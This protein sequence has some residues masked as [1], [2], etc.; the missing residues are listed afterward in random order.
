MPQAGSKQVHSKREKIS[1]ATTTTGMVNKAPKIPD[2]KNMGRKARIVVIV[3]VTGKT[4]PSRHQLRHLPFFT[5]FSMPVIFSATTMASSTG[6]PK[7]RCH[8]Y[9]SDNMILTPSW[10]KMT[11]PRREGIP[12]AVRG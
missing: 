12:K 6:G 3:V 2:K 10:K 9:Q 1:A 4:F 5:H 8:G 7:T 11:A